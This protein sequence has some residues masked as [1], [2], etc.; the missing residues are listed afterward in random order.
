M[1][2]TED[3]LKA[4]QSTGNVI[5]SAG[6]GSGKTSVLTERIYYN[7]KKGVKI[8]EL[9]VLT[10]TVAAAE[11]M[12]VRIKKELQKDD[13]TKDLV[14]LIDSANISTFDSYFLYLVK[15]Y[16]SL[17]HLPNNIDNIPDDVI[18][19]KKYQVLQGILKKK[20]ENPDPTFLKIIHNYCHKNDDKL[21]KFIIE[22]SKVVSSFKE[23]NKFLDSYYDN[24]LSDEAFNRFITNYIDKIII[25]TKNE[26]L[27]LL[28]KSS[29]DKF[30]E[31]VN[32][33]FT[34]CNG[35]TC[36]KDFMDVDLKSAP[37]LST[38]K[39]KLDEEE[40]KLEKTIRE[41][42]NGVANRIKLYDLNKLYEVDLKNN[43]EI[44]PYIL[45]IVREL[46]DEINKFKVQKGFFTF[47]DI[48]FK[49]CNLLIDFPEVRE[50]IKNKLKLIMIDEYQ[51]TSIFQEEF[52]NLISNNN[53]F[54]VGDVKQSIYGFRDANPKQF[55][56][57]Y[58]A[59]SDKAGGTAINMNENF[60]SRPEI[61]DAVNEL[62]SVIMDINHGGANYKLEHLIKTGN[63]KYATELKSKDKHGIFVIPFDCE[64]QDKDSEIDLTI[65][66]IKKRITN[67]MQVASYDP[68]LDKV[69]L[70]DIKY[71]DITLLIS[72]STDFKMF[73]DKFAEAGI[74]LNAVYDEDLKEDASIIVLINILK[75][76]NLIITNTDDNATMKHC[77]FSIAR[78]FLFAYSDQ[79]LYEISQDDFKKDPL[80]TKI[81]NFAIENKKCLLSKLYMNVI[82]EFDFIGKLSRLG[83]AINKL[84]YLKV[85]YNRTLIMDKLDYELNDFILYL[86]K[87]D[88]LDIKMESRKT[89]D[90]QNAVTLTTIHKSKGLEYN[91]VYLPLI[92]SKSGGNDKISPFFV[93][94]KFGFYL[95]SLYELDFSSNPTLNKSLHKMFYD[96]YCELNTYDEKMRLLYVAL[97]RAKE[98]VI[99]PFGSYY[100]TKIDNNFDAPVS[101][102][103][104]NS[105]NIG[106]I[107]F[108]SKINY[109]TSAYFNKEIIE[110]EDDETLENIPQFTI[111]D[112]N[113]NFP[114]ASKHKASKDLTNEFNMDALRYGTHIHLLMES[115]NFINKDTSL[116]SS[117][118]DRKIIDKIL[119]NNIFSNLKDAKI[120]KEYEFY[121]ET[122]E[123]HG[124]I[125]LF[126]EHNDFIDIIDYKLKNL[127]DDAYKEQLT[128]YKNYLERKFL[129]KCNMYL[130]SIL[131]NELREIYE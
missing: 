110:I 23:P 26:A 8:D 94:S 17:L 43:Q 14:P 68:K 54:V 105:K 99:I 128:I 29:C 20:Y 127:D 71:K 81:Y 46:E 27:R 72:K 126:I 89:S 5:V 98:D 97:T 111:R 100:H 124:V 67:K 35:F 74:P 30:I 75:M 106:D 53:V 3:Q 31:Y 28:R 66:D 131:N 50:S 63:E 129:K 7:I 56:D 62:F 79:K 77:F 83:N 40:K 1:K 12:K 125:D 115:V 95:P 116:I 73:E 10:F 82:L 76:I 69:I 113:Y 25:N 65:E 4:I 84:Q 109:P 41:L 123:I 90:A 49:A 34:Y 37:P 51:D 42:I 60:R 78:S 118:R 114:K 45:N 80:Y 9:L 92:F 21:F 2:R 93:D 86:E 52:I 96:D 85:F 39:K 47:N 108:A 33:Y 120:Y 102:M 32:N 18:L 11:E 121:D 19:I 130:L 122:N 24:Y 117:S 87:L 38:G 15:K 44:I 6:A 48:A 91:V 101:E 103:I 57:K 88:E 22:I 104:E 16:S 59:Y 70:R 61:N 119:T 112:F 64:K 36:L 55:I 107:L 58:Q 13:S